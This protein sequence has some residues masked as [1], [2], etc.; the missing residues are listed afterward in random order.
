[1]ILF[2]SPPHRFLR[3]KGASI[4][5]NSKFESSFFLI[6][7]LSHRTSSGIILPPTAY[8][9]LITL[10]CTDFFFCPMPKILFF[11]LLTF[12]HQKPS[13]TQVY[14]ELLI[15]SLT[16][17]VPTDFPPRI[18]SSVHI[19]FFSFITVA[20]VVSDSPSWIVF[21]AALLKSRILN[22]LSTS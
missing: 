20:T 10:N 21:P 1:M 7:P 19:Q 9:G 3:Q 8:W 13:I 5:R 6:T 12:C 17:I 15:P 14:A 4:S 11:V 16:V 2:L 18:I 22:D